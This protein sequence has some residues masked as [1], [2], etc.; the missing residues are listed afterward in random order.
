MKERNL[1]D[2]TEPN[3]HK[4]N[5]ASSQWAIKIKKVDDGGS[6]GGGLSFQRGG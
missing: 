5:K 1:G 3:E 4:V 2:K 6:G